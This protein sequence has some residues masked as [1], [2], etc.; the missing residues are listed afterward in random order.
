MNTPEIRPG[1]LELPHPPLPPQDA[2]EDSWESGFAH[3]LK[4][5]MGMSEVAELRA[6]LYEVRWLREAERV[7]AKKY[8]TAL[9]PMIIYT[10]LDGAANDNARAWREWGEVEK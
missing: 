6:A 2:G 1:L 9:G 5:C 8:E 10:G 7:G 4:S 3:L